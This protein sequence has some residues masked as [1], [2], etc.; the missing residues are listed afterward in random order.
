[1]KQTSLFQNTKGL[2]EIMASIAVIELWCCPMI[3]F[4]CSGDRAHDVTSDNRFVVQCCLALSIVFFVTSVVLYILRRKRG[5][6]VVIPSLVL[7]VFQPAWVYGGGG[8]D[9][10]LSMASDAQF[11]AVLLGIGVA[12]QLRS[13]LLKRA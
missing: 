8:G 9:C 4:A 3:A 6:W 13:W 10:G 11:S 12:H 7:L 2:V 5:L 1:M